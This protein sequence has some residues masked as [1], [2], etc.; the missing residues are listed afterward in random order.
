MVSVRNMV[1]NHWERSNRRPKTGGETPEAVSPYDDIAA[2][3]QA[4]DESWISNWR[5]MLIEIA[6][7]RLERHQNEN[8]GSVLYSALRLRSSFPELDSTGLSQKLSELAGREINA[9]AYRQHLK[10]G[11]VRFAE[12]VVEEIAQGLDVADAEHLQQ[13]LIEVGLYEYIR[14]VLPPNW[15][16]NT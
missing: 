5:A 7:T 15:K 1:K 16:A 14:D 13:E 2:F 9:A 4:A 8:P 12:Y 10:R 3:S 6:M 11:R